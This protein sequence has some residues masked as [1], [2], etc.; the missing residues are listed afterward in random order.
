MIPLKE[1][2]TV[3]ATFQKWINVYA[4]SQHF[5]QR[6][7]CGKHFQIPPG[8]KNNATRFRNNNC[9]WHN[10]IYGHKFSFEAQFVKKISVQVNSK[11]ITKK[12]DCFFFVIR[13]F[14]A[15][16]YFYLILKK[17]TAKTLRLVKRKI[18]K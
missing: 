16:L 4:S 1:V 8:L 15:R 3:S 11:V 14:F 13:N 6:R 5:F 17:F 7:G 2:E 18:S 9:L 12:K 10:N